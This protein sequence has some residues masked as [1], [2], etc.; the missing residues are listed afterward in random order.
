MPV[1]FRFK[2]SLERNVFVIEMVANV[3]FGKAFE[4]CNLTGIVLS[5]VGI[6]ICFKFIIALD[7]MYYL[8]FQ[9]NENEL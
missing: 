8:L 2:L 3:Y 9:R 4:K 7:S 5:G 6:Q 1:F